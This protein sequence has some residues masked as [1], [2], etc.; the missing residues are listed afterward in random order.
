MSLKIFHAGELAVQK[1]AGAPE[2]IHKWASI[3]LRDHLIDE[4]REFFSQLPFLIV[5]A[6]DDEGRPWCSLLWGEPGFARASNDSSLTVSAHASPGDPLHNQ[7]AVDSLVGLLGIELHSKRRN[8]LNG[9]ISASPSPMQFTMNVQQSYGNCR[10]FITPR[11]I[12]PLPCRRPGLVESVSHL[13]P[14]MIELIRTADTFF[15]ASGHVSD[16]SSRS[17][18]FD[19][20][21]RG[22]LSGFIQV[23]SDTALTFPDYSGN[24]LF[25]TL[26]NLSEDPR[27]GLLFIDFEQGTLLHLTGRITI[28]WDS[29]RVATFNN[30]RRLLLFQLVEA[31]CREAALPLTFAC[32]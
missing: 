27:A 15:I 5:A 3:A 1:R 14:S 28:D 11:R 16:E 25:N 32:V 30:A 20:S 19:A 17:A 7:L 31:V 12:Q 2:A 18:G 29:P 4:H 9:R 23:D 13:T 6:A 22:G 8:R 21:H 26:G 10:K 24:H